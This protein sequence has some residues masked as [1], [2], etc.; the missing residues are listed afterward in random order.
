MVKCETSL[1]EEI[2]H[3][4]Y[5]TY[6]E[7]MNF[8]KDSNLDLDVFIDEECMI[9]ELNIIKDGTDVDIWLRYVDS[10]KTVPKKL[11][12]LQRG[13]SYFIDSKSYSQSKVFW[14]KYLELLVEQSKPL[15]YRQHRSLFIV[16]N[17]AFEKFLIYFNDIEI[18]YKFLDFLN[19][20]SNVS[21]I[22]DVYVQ[23]LRSTDF[24]L[25]HLIWPKFLQFSDIVAKYSTKLASRILL[26]FISYG[27]YEIIHLSKLLEL[28]EDYF[29]QKAKDIFLDGDFSLDEWK[30]ILE[31]LT[32]ESMIQ[33]FLEKFPEEYGFGYMQ[34]INHSQGELKVHYYNKALENC[35]SVHEFTTIYEAY[36]SYLES[37]LT[38]DAS[39]YDIDNFENMINNRQLMISN[40]YLKGDAQNLDFWFKKFQIFEDNGDLNSLLKAYVSA[41]TTVNPLKSYGEYK[42]SD[43]WIK[44]AKVYSDRKD[45][46]TANL[47]YSKSLKSKFKNNEEL[48][49]LYINWLKMFI[50]ND[51]VEEGVEILENILVKKTEDVSKSVKLWLYYFEVLEIYV[52]DYTK[53]INAYYKMI[54]LRYATPNVIFLMASFLEGEGQIK[55]LFKIYEYSLSQFNDSEIKFQIFNHYLPKLMRHEKNLEVVRDVF[56]KGLFQLPER[57]QPPIIILYS[58][59]EYDNGLII[60]SFNLLNNFI[61]KTKTD[62]IEL[63]LI[64]I[65]KFNNKIDL[66]DVLEKYTELKLA[67]S[68]F[69]SLL[70]EFITFEKDNKEY[71]RVRYLYQYLHTNANHPYNDWEDFELEHGDESTFKNFIRFKQTHPEVQPQG[72]VKAELSANKPTENPDEI[73][74]DM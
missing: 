72:F 57:F 48:V 21:Y 10:V 28:K 45:L 18:W 73:D 61:L 49:E 9:H 47:I 20:Q 24:E 69:I 4:S 60:K 55:E 6:D 27:K 8:I 46:K 50:E 36:L 70:K 11:I 14:I 43:I 40:I 71:S 15:N 5:M 41:I 2:V 19:Q 33:R 39:D 74:L 3:F 31:Y 38:D 34:L 56:D 52:D 58:E 12:I 25:H 65:K 59:F 66:R 35:K 53:I 26:N 67:P 7:K 29:V 32:D 37:L 54:E 42:L 22:L 23:C 30:L 64:V 62:P 1:R 17:K 68:S 16:I 44:Y 51:R 13:I 63:M